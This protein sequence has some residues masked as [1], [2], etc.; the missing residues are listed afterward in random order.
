LSDLLGVSTSM[1]VDVDSVEAEL[2]TE[3]AT[4]HSLRKRKHLSTQSFRSLNSR[5]TKVLLV[6][7]SARLY[8]APQ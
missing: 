6:K 3:R 1:D 2:N 4:N 5:Q 7:S 8:K